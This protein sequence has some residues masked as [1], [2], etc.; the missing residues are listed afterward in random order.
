MKMDL[1]TLIYIIVMIVFILL[2]AFGKKKKPVQQAPLPA[3]GDDDSVAPED[4]IAEKLKAF[5]GN[6]DKEESESVTGQESYME[7]EIIDT[8][9]QETVIDTYEEPLYRYKPKVPE[10]DEL[11]DKVHDIHDE[12]QEGLPVFET[13]DYDRHSEMLDG[14][15]TKAENQLADDTA[16]DLVKDAVYEDLDLRKA[17]IY[18][19]IILKPRH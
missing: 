8:I 13:Y 19:E 4:L 14:D 3:E 12:I 17:I 15:L 16:Y 9:P 7:E 2:G 1:D 11:L 6:Y 18:S 5:F 10:E